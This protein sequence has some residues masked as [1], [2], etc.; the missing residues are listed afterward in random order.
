MSLPPTRS[1]SHLVVHK[2]P[3]FV[4][5]DMGGVATAKPTSIPLAVLRH[6]PFVR[7][8]KIFYLEKSRS[9]FSLACCI[10]LGGGVDVYNLFF[11]GLALFVWSAWT[12]ASTCLEGSAGSCSRQGPSWLPQV[13]F[14]GCKSTER[15]EGNKWVLCVSACPAAGTWRMV[16]RGRHEPL[17]R[18][19]LRLRLE[20]GD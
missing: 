3:G 11:P 4:L 18:R 9:R 5:G 10:V 6:S 8:N 15:R 16:E 2:E 7:E 1:V 12:P 17:T 13:V 19:Q 14:S 20:P